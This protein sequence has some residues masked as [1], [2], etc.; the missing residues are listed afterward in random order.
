MQRPRPQTR[1]EDEVV[2]VGA[3]MHPLRDLYHLLLRASGPGLVGLI[4]AGFLVLNLIFA[5]VYASVG[6]ITNVEAGSVL[7][8]F[9]FSVQT[10]GTIGYGGMLPTSTAAH[11]VV[12]LE[13]VTSLVFTAIATGLVFAKF[14]QS[15]A[16]I[17]FSHEACI[18]PMNGVPTLSFRV[19]ND[20]AST[21]LE[22]TIRVALIRTERTTEGTTFYRMVDLPLARERT[23]A[24]NR[25]WNV[26]HSITESSP[27][28]GMDAET[29]A[30]NEIELLVT[31]VGTDDVSLQPVHARHRYHHD[32]VRFGM[33]HAD[34]LRELPD[35][36]LELDLRNFHTLVPAPSAR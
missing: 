3:R 36:R 34:V 28:H 22:T 25:S 30:A 33:R 20:R 35:G 9:F 7:E 6:G 13:A 18:S 27:L 17:V 21:V 12:V 32:E 26:L 8:A 5:L 11:V 14:S 24:L 29:L 10:F 19:G 23:P 2:V 4:V 31:V 16:R 1:L 15:V